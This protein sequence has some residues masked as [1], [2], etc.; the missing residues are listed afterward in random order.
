MDREKYP[1]YFLGVSVLYA[2]VLLMGLAY[3]ILPASSFATGYGDFYLLSFLLLLPILLFA[4]Y[5][6]FNIGILRILITAVTVVDFVIVIY[7]MILL[8]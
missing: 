6:K 3:F 5:E 7:F 1:N 8:M 4:L 2:I